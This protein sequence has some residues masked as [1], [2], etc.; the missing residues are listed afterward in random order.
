MWEVSQFMK[1]RTWLMY[2][3]MTLKITGYSLSDL[4][5]MTVNDWKGSI[6]VLIIR[7]Y[8]RIYMK[9]LRKNMKTSSH[10]SPC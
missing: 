2:D 6:H 9:G 7:Y 4:G 8:P 10:W 5:K 3:F 1:G